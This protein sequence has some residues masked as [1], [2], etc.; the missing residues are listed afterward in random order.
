MFLPLKMSAEVTKIQKIPKK[1][2][3]GQKSQ[4]RPPLQPPRHLRHPHPTWPPWGV[5]KQVI[6]GTKLH[7]DDSLEGT[8]VTNSETDFGG[9]EKNPH[10]MASIV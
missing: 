4:K 3:I 8:Y 6:G 7:L 5:K 9:S 2:K 10:M 1:A